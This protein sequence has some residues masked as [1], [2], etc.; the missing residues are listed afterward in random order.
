MP[1][2]TGIDYTIPMPQRE[3][4]S[5]WY[6]RNRELA[7]QRAS[8][9]NRNHPKRRREISRRSA[10]KARLKNP[11]RVR[12]IR[13]KSKMKRSRENRLA[14]IYH[15]GGTPPKC[16]CCG[17]GEFLFL[18]IDHIGGKA[19]HSQSGA[20]Q[21]GDALYRWI[22]K[23]DFPSGFRILCYNCN[24]AK[25]FYGRCPHSSSTPPG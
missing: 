9:W 19:K 25:G 2:Y 18:S 21:S 17:E 3:N 5:R 20:R 15:Y 22:V 24:C 13:R 1:L 6:R 8:E 14:I 23:N 4:Q 7:I 12:E 11:E 16:A 10:R